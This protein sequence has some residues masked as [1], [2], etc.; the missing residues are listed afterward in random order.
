M[1][2]TRISISILWLTVIHLTLSAM[3]AQD[4]VMEMIHQAQHQLPNVSNLQSEL[5]VFE[6]RQVFELALPLS[7]QFG[8]LHVTDSTSRDMSLPKWQAML[9]ALGGD[10]EILKRFAQLRPSFNE[11]EIQVSQQQDGQQEIYQIFDRLAEIETSVNNSWSRLWPKLKSSV[12]VVSNLYD[13]FDRYQRNAA[14]VNE[15][16]LRDYAETVHGQDGLTTSQAIEE[17]H[18]VVCPLDMAFIHNDDGINLKKSGNKSMVCSGGAF[19][20]LEMALGQV[21]TK[22]VS[23]FR[24]L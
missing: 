17:I 4:R 9:R 12:H 22:Y 20:V 13:W 11:L 8:V 14:V 21:C 24:S 6:N 2:V 1:M 23:S 3:V 10:R 18:Q 16:T 19:E 5:L 7:L 15:R